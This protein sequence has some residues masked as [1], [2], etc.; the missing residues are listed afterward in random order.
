MNLLD[1]LKEKIL[2]GDGA[3]GTFLYSQGY[4][5]C[6][7]KLNITDEEL[8][9]SVHEKYIAAGADVIQTNTYAANR[10]KLA[11][12]N[13]QDEIKQINRASVKIARK[14]ARNN[15]FVLGTIGGIQNIRSSEFRPEEIFASLRE[16]VECL[17]DADVDGLIF[18][19][20]Y[21]LE[22]LK[23][24]VTFAKQQTNKPI[25]AQIALGE[26]GVLYD[27]T[28]I[29]E[30]FDQLIQAGSD[31]IGLNCRMGPYH[32]IRSFEEVPIY[33]HTF[34]SAYPNASL[35]DYL[36]GRFVYQLNTE[37][38]YESALKFREQGV[39]LLG[40]CCGTTP[41]HIQAIAEALKGVQPITEKV[42][43]VI[44]R[45]TV[46][47]S[48]QQ[49]EEPLSEIVKKR[50]SVIVELDPPKQL[51]SVEKFLE[52]AKQL[53]DAGVDA[54]T[55]ADNSLASPRIDNMALGAVLKD[56]LGIR[57]L[58]HLTCR[59]R[60]LIGLQSHLLGLAALGINDVLAI[61]GDPTKVGDFPGATSVY[62]LT[63]FDLIRLIKQL[64]DGI[65]FSGKSIGQKTNFDVAAAFNPNVRH[66][67][68][69]VIRMEKKIEN[70]ADYFMSQPIYS[71]EQI[72]EVYHAT[73]HIDKPI[74]IGI[75][76]L[77]SSKNAQFLHHEVPGIKLTDDILERMERC[78]D[79]RKLA[80]Q[81]GIA[82]SKS[83]IDT[84]LEY[85]HGIYLMTPFLRYEITVELTKYILDK[86]SK[87]EK[88]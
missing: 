53:R 63:S 31:I 84:A 36:D 32:M 30:A 65:S 21:N 66:L 19:T 13:L 80:Q 23:E 39:R 82:I 25:I 87:R 40:G 15:Q 81:E 68:R 59:D 38:F 5:D 70:G 54:V 56:Q 71:S 88:V 24:V 18:E 72:E 9:Y 58:V 45:E 44:N 41:E 78:G 17:L 37:Y 10:L 26:I 77:T 14:A 1:T 46:V 67:D 51:S 74:Y 33:N 4:H 85:F 6:F 48:K 43:K 55:M 3:I 49:K 86:V 42:V 27:G 52:G 76:P 60:N 47:V 75:M 28:P 12:Y 34:L 62:D 35:P 20:F 7:E 73:K 11:K 8:I 29:G 69:A 79:D 50:S 61:T 22:E 16:Q 57:P 2:I 83:L 64:N